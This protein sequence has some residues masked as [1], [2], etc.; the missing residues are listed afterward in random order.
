MSKFLVAVI[1]A[2][3]VMGCSTVCDL[4]KAASA[5]VSSA[6][7]SPA[8]LNCTGTAAIQKWVDAKLASINVCKDNKTAKVVGIAMSDIGAVVCAPLVEILASTAL[9]QIPADWQCAG[10]ILTDQGKAKVL[11]ACQ[12]AL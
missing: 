9:S 11:A 8:V 10:G 7:A 12:A 4:S 3:G 6:V 5:A 1:F 2:F